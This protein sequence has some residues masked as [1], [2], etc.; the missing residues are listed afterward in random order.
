VQQAVACI[1][2]TVC[3]AVP[4]TPPAGGTNFKTEVQGV[5]GTHAFFAVHT[6]VSNFQTTLNVV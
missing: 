6:I 1:S 2:L 5:C 3:V 4:H